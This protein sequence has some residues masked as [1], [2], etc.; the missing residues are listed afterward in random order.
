M[1]ISLQASAAS[2]SGGAPRLCVR[3]LLDPARYDHEVRSPSLVETHISW[4][5]LTGPYAYKIKKPVAPGFLDFSTLERRRFYCHEEL[6]LNRRLAP[7]IYLSVVPITGT[8]EDPRMGGEGT[9]IEYAVQMRQFPQSALMDR[10]ARCGALG[11]EDID[12]LARRVAEFHGCIESAPADSGFGEPC[13]VHDPVEGNFEQLLPLIDDPR[14]RARLTALREASARAWRARKDVL[15]SRKRGGFVRECHGDLHLGNMA[16]IDARI[17]IFDGIEFSEELRWIDVMSEIALLLADLDHRGH[18]AL[19]WRF[20]NRYLEHTG[21]YAGV[22]ILPYYMCYR[23]MVRAK[24]ARLRLAQSGLEQAERDTLDA[25]FASYLGLAERCLEPGK[26]RLVITRGLSGCGKTT[27]AEA[28]LAPLGAV[29]ARSDIERKRLFGLAPQARSGSGLESGIYDPPASRE[30]YE[31]LRALA[32][33]VIEAGYTAIVDATFLEPSTRAR[34]KAL[35]AE[36][37]VPFVILDIEAD[38][39]TLRA[40]IARRAEAGRDASEADLAVLERQLGAWQPL[41]PE[42][43]ADAVAVDGAHPDAN[44]IAQAVARAARDS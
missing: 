9:P 29:R 10:L 16:R 42:E 8:H 38:E 6:R 32:G 30:T 27:I 34:F 14:L 39:P 4:V 26:P 36:H 18:E 2:S 3:A 17:V 21:D 13:R 31:R 15:A 35:A 28:L 12:A 33:A 24:V 37:R 40:R 43:R 25:E 41:A 23:A 1:S 5:V 20:L 11:P 44:A 7:D 19:A 22:R